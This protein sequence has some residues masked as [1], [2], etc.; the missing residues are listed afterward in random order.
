MWTEASENRP[1]RGRGTAPGDLLRECRRWMGRSSLLVLLILR[2]D[3][4]DFIPTHT[5]PFPL[6]VSNESRGCV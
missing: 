2:S 4:S 6:D 3:N 5:L 1:P